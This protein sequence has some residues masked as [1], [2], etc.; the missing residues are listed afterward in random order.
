MIA[1]I[2]DQRSWT[3][4]R[5]RI[6]GVMLVVLF[7]ASSI[8]RCQRSYEYVQEVGGKRKKIRNNDCHSGRRW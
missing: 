4:L 7:L 2:D 8:G 5:E 6:I 1:F 3:M